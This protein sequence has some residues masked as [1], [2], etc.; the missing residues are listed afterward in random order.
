MLKQPAIKGIF[1]FLG[2][3]LFV[4]GWAAAV[5]FS[6][7]EHAPSQDGTLVFED[8]FERTEIGEHYRQAEADYKSGGPGTWT[9]QNGR[10]RA[11]NIHNAAL[12]LK[13]PLP[14][15]V[16]VEFIARALTDTGDLKCE[17]FGDGKTHQSGYI[18]INGG[19]NNRVRG[20]FRQDEHSKEH[21]KK[22][23]DCPTVGK[24]R[25]PRCVDKGVDQNWT[26]ERYD[27]RVRWYIDGHLVITYDDA[28]PLDGRHFAFN[29][30]KAPTEFDQLRIYDLGGD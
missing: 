21:V 11:E 10:L 8:D 20:I 12:W 1:I 22:D 14:T 2:L 7:P 13:T 23:R 25:V 9:I 6:A 15:N 3:G 27:A 26:I 17:I 5:R 28:F 19:W 30:W 16:R 4:V 29:N 18:L 24:N